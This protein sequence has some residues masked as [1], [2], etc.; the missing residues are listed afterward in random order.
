[1]AGF[2]LHASQVGAHESVSGLSRVRPARR[3]AECADD[4][5][6][7]PIHPARFKAHIARRRLPGSRTSGL[8]NINLSS[9]A[10]ARKKWGSSTPF[11]TD[12]HARMDNSRTLS[13]RSSAGASRR[14][15]TIPSA[16]PA[17]DRNF[18]ASCHRALLSHTP[19]I[20]LQAIRSI[21][22]FSSVIVV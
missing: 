9:F 14:G 11:V 6:S 7:S 21:S 16:S 2:R 8:R 10:I 1:M 4:R 22:T 15:T 20:A 17:A 13:L 19:E 5:K 18:N 12:F 3:S